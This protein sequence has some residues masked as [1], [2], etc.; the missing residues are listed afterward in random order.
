MYIH[1]TKSNYLPFSKSFI[2]LNK[3]VKITGNGVK[4]SIPNMNNIDD[5]FKNVRLS[6]PRKKNIKLMF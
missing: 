6:I 1:F 5:N 2:K 3:V 4:L